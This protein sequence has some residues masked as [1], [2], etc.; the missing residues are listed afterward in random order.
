M[1]NGTAEKILWQNG[2]YQHAYTELSQR[3][4]HITFI[5]GIPENLNEYVDPEYRNLI[6]TDDPMSE[7]GN[8]KRITSLFTK[9]SHH[10]NVSVILLLQNLFYNGKG[11][12]NISLNTHYIMLF[13]NPRDNTVISS[14]AK[15]MYLGK[16]KFLQPGGI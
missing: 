12:C 10:K 4:P 11:S 7:T 15:Q 9:G 1:T 8:D 6:I 13:K 16:T 5:E 14:L 3:F 2:E